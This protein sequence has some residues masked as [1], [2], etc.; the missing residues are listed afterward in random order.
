MVLHIGTSPVYHTFE[1]FHLLYGQNK[2]NESLIFLASET[3]P[4]RDL[5]GP[6]W[7]PCLLLFLS[8]PWP[9]NMYQR[10]QVDTKIYW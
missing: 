8:V 6:V 10:S 7:T 1:I 4:L 9:K 3:L 2:M 5:A